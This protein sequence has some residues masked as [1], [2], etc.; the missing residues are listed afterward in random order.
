ML[1]MAG[2]PDLPMGSCSWG[3][4]ERPC[5][6]HKAPVLFPELPPVLCWALGTGAAPWQQQQQPWVLP[7]GTLWDAELFWEY[8]CKW[9]SV[10]LCMALSGCGQFLVHRNSPVLAWTLCAAGSVH[11]CVGLLG[12]GIFLAVRSY[13]LNFGFQQG[14][15]VVIV[16]FCN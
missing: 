10:S 4:E 2:T 7:C 9:G 6:K 16:Q 11:T 12:L 8:F 15:A 1:R 14:H 3:R 5:V 13:H